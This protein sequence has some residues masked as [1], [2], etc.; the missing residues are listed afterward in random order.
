MDE[1]VVIVNS[2]SSVKTL[3]DYIEQE[4]REEMLRKQISIQQ[5]EIDALQKKLML[6]ESECQALR[7]QLKFYIS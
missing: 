2:G 1:P 6:L 5:E 3:G 7:E 4:A